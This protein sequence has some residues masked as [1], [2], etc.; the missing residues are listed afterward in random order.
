M[1]RERAGAGIEYVMA[2]KTDQGLGKGITGIGLF[3]ANILYIYR[4]VR[5]KY[6]VHKQLVTANILY[7]YRGVHFKYPVYKGVIWTGKRIR[8]DSLESA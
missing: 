5:G 2:D 1:I 7:I 8:L 4:T 3:T 6:P